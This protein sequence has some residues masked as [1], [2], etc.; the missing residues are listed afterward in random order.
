[1]ATRISRIPRRRSGQRLEPRKKPIQERSR[2]TLERLLSAAAQVFEEH[3][4]AAGTSN[5]I[6][7]RAG[8]S[9]GTFYQYFP[10]KEA[11]AVVLLERHLEETRRRLH[12]WVG[13]TVAERH[14]LHGAL[15]DYVEGMLETHAGQPRLQHILLEETPLPERVHE[16]LLR[17]ER[18][19]VQTVAGLLRRYPEVQRGRLAHAGFFVVQAVESLTHRFAAHPNEAQIA[20]HT[21]ADELV[22]MLEGYLVYR[23]EPTDPSPHRPHGSLIAKGGNRIDPGSPPRRKVASGQ[24]HRDQ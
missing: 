13:H 16:A 3:G 14:S 20:R 24:G 4:Y 23:K 1:V 15:R 9:I 7:E 10:S 18:E 22:L 8:L 21:F 12:E 19:A 2:V 6:A 17:A 11:A 5:R